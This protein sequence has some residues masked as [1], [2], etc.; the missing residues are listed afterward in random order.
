MAYEI[1]E[2]RDKSGKKFSWERYAVMNCYDGRFLEWCDLATLCADYDD[3][4][5]NEQLGCEGAAIVS[6]RQAEMIVKNLTGC[7]DEYR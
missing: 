3:P 2:L 7:K 4:Q 6:K 1:Y 5:M